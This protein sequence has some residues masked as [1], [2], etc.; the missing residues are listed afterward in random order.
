[1]TRPQVRLEQVDSLRAVAA[2]SVVAYHYGAGYDGLF[3]HSSA[4]THLFSAPST[5]VQLFFAISGFVILMTLHRTRSMASFLISRLARL[6]PAYLCCAAFTAATVALAGAGVWPLDWRALAWSPL[7]VTGLVNR[8]YIDPSYW[9]LSL[10][11]VFYVAAGLAY[12]HGRT[13]TLIG[14][15]SLWVC[16]TAGLRLA[17]FVDVDSVASAY[18]LV[19]YVHWFGLGMAVHE[20]WAGRWRTA[21]WLALP[22]LA[23]GPICPP[24]AA[25][26]YAWKDLVKMLVFAGALYLAARR[27]LPGASWRPLVFI[28]EISYA[29]YLL[30]Q[31]I[32]Y[33]IIARLE[34]VG[35]TPWAAM[36]LATAAVFILSAAV[37][38]WVERPAQ[39]AIRATH[40]RRP[41]P[42]AGVVSRG[43]AQ[44][45][46]A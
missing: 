4:V 34:A 30:H 41:M 35:W 15:M 38:R 6:Y 25:S 37:R 19:H 16:L 32:G 39:A 28:G 26:L 46:G 7:M 42:A 2:L 9:T 36:G 40:D 24:N 33:I 44:H 8:R 17:K 11:M 29:L 21:A 14:L 45:S 1:M 18:T 5:G 22:V 10:E 13:R 27:R 3:G 31:V 12:F 20:G 43:P 23:F